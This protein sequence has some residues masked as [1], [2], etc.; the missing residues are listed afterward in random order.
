MIRFLIL[1]FY[2]YVPVALYLLFIYIFSSLSININDI[3]VLGSDK[4][5]H[6]LEYAVLGFLFMRAYLNTAGEEFKVRGVF[7]TVFFAF[8]FG[9]SDEYHQ[10]YVP[11]RIVSLGDILADTIGGFLGSIFYIFVLYVIS[12]KENKD[13]ENN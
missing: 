9:C 7:T 8:L 13:G 12:L 3:P 2:Y 1:F 5:M 6:I 4:I 11:N 10:L